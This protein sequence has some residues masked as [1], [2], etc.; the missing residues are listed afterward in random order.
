MRVLAILGLLVL[1]ISSYGQNWTDSIFYSDIRPNEELR[2]HTCYTDILEYVDFDDNYDD[3]FISVRKGD[4]IFGNLICNDVHQIVSDLNLNRGDIIEMGWM[5]DS[6]RPEGDKELLWFK[7]YA[8]KITKIKDVENTPELSRNSGTGSAICVEGEHEDWDEIEVV[9][10][11]VKGGDEVQERRKHWKTG[12]FLDKIESRKIT[13][14]LLDEQLE[15]R[16]GGEF[17]CIVHQLR[18]RSSY[19]EI[20]RQEGKYVIWDVKYD[21]INEGVEC[22]LKN[23]FFKDFYKNDEQ[24]EQVWESFVRDG[25]LQK[26][27]D[28]VNEIV[29]DEFLDSPLNEIYG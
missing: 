24:R 7:E 9:S 19:F 4:K 21:S 11:T 28:F 10:I 26:V 15:I 22:Y 17:P 2:L 5:I 8:L 27:L 25:G 13:I 1:S 3:F 6:L 16:E 14:P 23:D 20:K 18:G 29:D 12:E